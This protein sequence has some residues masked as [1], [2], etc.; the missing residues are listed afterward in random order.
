M[1]EVDADLTVVG[2]GPG[3]YVAAIRAAQLGMKVVVVE[4]GPL[5]GV[6]LNWGCIPVKALLRSAEVYN[7]MKKAGEFGLSAGN[8][9]FD[10]S[11][12]IRRSRKTAGRLS[13]GIGYLF[14]K[15]QI[16]TVPGR[17][18]LTKNRGILV[19]D[20]AGNETA[21][22]VSKFTLLAAGAHPAGLPFAPFDGKRI[23]SSADAMILETPP[24]S[25]LIIG[26]GAI[27]IEF[28]DFYRTFGT[29]ITIVELLPHVLPT[30]DPDIAAVLHRSFRKRKMK[31][32]TDTVVTDIKIGKESVT[33]YAKSPEGEQELAAERLLVSVGVVP[34]SDGLGLEEAGVEVE[35]GFIRIN[36]MYRTSVPTIYAVGDLIGPPY[37]AHVASAE[38]IT[39]VEHMAGLEVSPLDTGTIPAA[40]YAHPQVARVGLTEDEAVKRGYEVKAGRFPFAAN[41]KALTMGETAGMVK[42]VFE[43]Q[44]GELLGG[45]IVGENA[46]E[47]I[48]EVTMAKR[49]GAT[50]RSI[51][52]TVHSH[53]TLSESIMEASGDAWGEAIHI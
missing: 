44:S 7:L 15:N 23:L 50:Y 24:K 30:E 37:L 27:G 25:L 45:H 47:L 32:L 1:N 4:K 48:G 13:G 43:A 51:L 34:N 42:L 39:A 22:V 11:E 2:S 46:S 31:I 14:K 29:E 10:F 41:G 5:G 33:V 19:L 17:G 52:K 26:A 6:C 36:E 35:R 3:G 9:D 21:R 8:L 28:A 16:E 40:V 20:S 53:P 49:H 38:G 12:I 18:V